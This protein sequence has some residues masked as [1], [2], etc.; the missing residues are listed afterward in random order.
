[1]IGIQQVLAGVAIGL[2]VSLAF[3][4]VVVAGEAV[5]LSMGLGFATMVDPQTGT[6]TPVVSQFL[7]IVAT[8][9]FLAVGGHLMLVQLLAESFNLL[10]VAPQGLDAHSFHTVVAW[11]SEM[12]S[13]AVL[14]ALPAIALLLTV[15]MVIGVMTRAAPQMNIFSVGFPLTMMVGLLALLMLVLPSLTPRLFDLWR[16]AFDTVR[17][18]FGAG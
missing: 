10:P 4:S 1:L 5:A 6:S 14:I 7:L 3:Q 9:V 17:Q 11:G 16:S 8:L 18:V 12:Y 15:N 13:G 2:L